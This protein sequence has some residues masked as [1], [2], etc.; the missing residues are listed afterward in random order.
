MKTYALTKNA[1]PVL[2][3]LFSSGTVSAERIARYNYLGYLPAAQKRI[4]IMADENCAGGKWALLD[5]TKK[6]VAT[7]VLANSIGGKGDHSP[8][9]FNYDVDFSN[10][11]KEGTY[12]CIIDK[13][14]PFSIAIK[15]AYF[16]E[17]IESN[18]RFLR[19]MRAGKDC[20]DHEPGHLKDSLCVIYH[21][22]GLKNTDAWSPDAVKKHANMLDGWYGGAIYTKSTSYIAHTTYY[23]LRAYELNPQLF[24]KKYSKT[25]LI[26]ILDEAR[27]GLEYLCKTM[28]NEKE[29]IIQ[30][31]DFDDDNGFVTLPNK[32]DRDGKRPAYSILT[33]PQMGMSAGA[34]A[35]GS[36][37]FS[38]LGLTGQAQRY[39]KMAEKIYATAEKLTTPPAWL[40]KDYE[41]FKDD[42]K[43]DNLEI[44]ARELYALTHKKEYFDAANKWAGRAKNGGGISWDV[45]NLQ[46]HLRIADKDSSVNNF[47]RED[48]GGL[49][50][51]ATA[52]G[53]YWN[54][55]ADYAQQALYSWMEAAS[56]ACLYQLKNKNEKYEPLI[57]SVINYLFGCNNWGVCFIA[58]QSENKSV[59][60]FRTP[61]YNLQKRLFPEG[62]I[63]FG[64]TD[65]KSHAEGEKWCCT[66][67]T[68][69][70]TY[71][72]NTVNAEFYDTSDD[73]S[74]MDSAIYGIADGIFLFTCCATMFS[75]KT[76]AGQ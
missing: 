72:F 18:L 58:L 14:A 28:P 23:L 54:L 8:M 60:A 47:I 3:L 27:V 5:Q 46:A 68:V 55:P 2:L 49:L 45:Q 39:Q 69:E 44:A 63:P 16:Q 26:D 62:G 38:S 43:Y 64:P 24:I 9:P 15:K 53:N 73:P 66:D 20:L 25:D 12:S 33:A 74:C 57:S 42:S 76:T 56:A 67:F 22:K 70:P 75:D 19:V 37:I 32:D 36:N 6:E 4:K 41:L 31:G 61:I 65:A 40:E 50:S 34:L 71:R 17:L 51:H 52:P 13:M 11:S 29:F 10:I 1:V 35:L 7:G 48:L 59:R 21:R 30:V